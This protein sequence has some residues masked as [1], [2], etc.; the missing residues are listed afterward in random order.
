MRLELALAHVTN[1]KTQV[2][3]LKHSLEEEVIVIA[4]NRVHF[5]FV[6]FFRLKAFFNRKINNKLTSAPKNFP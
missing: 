6:L 1:E 5:C 4:D 3:G 2:E